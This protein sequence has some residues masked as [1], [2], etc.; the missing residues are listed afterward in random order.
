LFEDEKVCP[1]CGSQYRDINV[2]V[3]EEI[4]IF[5]SLEMKKFTDGIRGFVVHLK[6]GWFPSNDKRKHSKGVDLVQVVD[7]ENDF[8]KKYVV[9]KTSGEIVKDLEQPLKDHQ[10]SN[11]KQ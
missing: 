3:T 5:E 8:Y 10:S 2:R 1:G 11:R 9:D 6:Q 4:G 7:R